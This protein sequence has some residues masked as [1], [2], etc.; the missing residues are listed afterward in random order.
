MVNIVVHSSALQPPIGV[1]SGLL[2]LN[3][4]VSQ[5]SFT[6]ITGSQKTGG[7]VLSQGGVEMYLDL[8]L[9]DVW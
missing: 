7:D 3:P 6:T 2:M 8:L 1:D 4:A 5:A 9:M